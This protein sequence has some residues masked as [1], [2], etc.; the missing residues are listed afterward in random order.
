VLMPGFPMPD[1]SAL[2][3]HWGYLG[4]FVAVALGNIGLPVPEETILALAGYAAQ[5]GQLH[6]PAVVAVGVISAVVGD[7]IGYWLGRR[8]G[9]QA[10]ER[11]G[12]WVRITPERL[13]KVSDFMTRYGALA[14]FA[15]RFVAGARFLAG[16]LAGAAGMS[17]VSFA[18]ANMLGALLYVP[19]AVGI[20]YGISYGFGDAIQR[21]S[22]HAEHI[23]LGAVVALTLAFVAVRV[24][25]SGHAA[26]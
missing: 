18:V 26:H 12:R 6:L 1:G 9:G 23:V 22:G 3:G 13:Q 21:L 8:Y 11:Y 19:Y 15:A 25:R 5:R 10:I 4:I 2:L 14:V 7:N 20:G 17:P 16:P 24:I